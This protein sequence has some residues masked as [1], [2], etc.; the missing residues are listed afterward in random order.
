MLYI[1]KKF[2]RNN[3]FVILYLVAYFIV[4]NLVTLNR[5]WQFEA[6]Y[7]D[8]GL[9]D[10]SIWKVAH[11]QAPLISH[12]FTKAPLLQLGDHFTPAI[13]LLSPIYWFTKSYLPILIIHN[14][15][16]FLSGVVLLKIAELFLK[17]KLMI[18]AIMIAF[19][20]FVG[21]QNAII[22]NF[23]TEILTLLPVSLM[24]FFMFKKQW[25][26]FYFFMFVALLFKESVAAL[27]FGVGIYLIFSSERKR[28]AIVIVSSIFYYLSVTKLIIPLI[29]GHQY[30][31]TPSYFDFNPISIILKFFSPD[32]K[33]QALFTSF[34]SF[35]FLPLLN[36]FFLPLILQDY[37][38]RFVIDG[39]ASRI[40]LGLHYNAIPSLL[41]A[42][43]SI[44]AVA[45]LNK[46]K[47]YRRL[48]NLHAIL[49]ILMILFFH[50]KLHGALGLSYNPAFY[51]HTKNLDFLRRFIDQVPKTKGLLM[52]QNNLAPQLTHSNNLM[53]LRADYWNYKPD[54][55]AIDIREG[56]SSNNY[57]PVPPAQFID[58]YQNLKKDKKYLMKKVTNDQVIFIKK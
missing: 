31:Y 7:F 1:M 11:F 18:F 20:L 35:S 40:D 47:T 25:K 48:I 43:S 17:N 9:F 36:P 32:L 10:Q 29:S 4:I 26:R 21:M 56:Q 34:A 2:I 16:L 33:I 30:F 22:A 42:V 27:T 28:G 13:Y 38:L 45:R 58:L 51:Q 57:W 5:F 44:L 19:T 53:L 6:Y 12:H 49:I 8:H 3:F 55:I 52:T 23:H 50:Y 41:L 54:I 24:L 15:F 39:A 37:F 14:L 46:F